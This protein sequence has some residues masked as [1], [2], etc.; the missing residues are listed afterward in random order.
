VSLIV[1]VVGGI[2]LKGLNT[3][4]G[5]GLIIG[6]KNPSKRIAKVLNNVSESFKEFHA[7]D[8]Q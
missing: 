6:A 8:P 5:H 4:A 1:P 7:A 3:N 2:P